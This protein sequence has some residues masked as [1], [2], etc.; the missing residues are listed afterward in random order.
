M[1]KEYK[2]MEFC[3]GQ[4]LGGCVLELV[5][6]AVKGE[7]VCADFNGHTLY[8]DTVSIDSASLEVTGSTYFDNLNA[9]ELNRQ[10]LIQE[11]KEYQAKVPEL[12]AVWIEKGHKILSEDKWKKWDECVPIRLSDLY[13][14]MELGM[15]LDIIKAIDEQSLEEA[16]EVM[17]GQGHSGMS[18]GLMKSMV[19]TFSDKGEEFIEL[20]NSNFRN[21]G[22]V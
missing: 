22:E 11:E 14:G 20:L 6:Y 3:C 7:F 16:V 1:K 10:K 5:K 17:K 15:C 8:S 21:E 18:W 13:H 2:K 9:R 4:T 19:E 12:T